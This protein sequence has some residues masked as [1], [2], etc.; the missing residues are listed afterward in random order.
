M[1]TIW[2][3]VSWAFISL[4][5]NSLSLFISEG[6]SL[7]ALAQAWRMRL[8]I[9]VDFVGCGLAA[10]GYGD[11]SWM[12]LCVY[13]HAVKRNLLNHSSIHQAPRLDRSSSFADLRSGGQHSP[14]QSLARYGF[15]AAFPKQL[16][17]YFWWKTK[18]FQHFF[19]SVNCSSDRPSLSLIISSRNQ[20]NHKL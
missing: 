19:Q 1:R 14:H 16:H 4:S 3:T 12:S 15:K 13:R 11:L 17:A 20:N 18:S 9:H 2:P 5:P 10:A 7:L 6:W 8:N